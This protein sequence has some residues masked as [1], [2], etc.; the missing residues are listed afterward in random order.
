MAPVS[1][2]LLL[3]A[4]RR[5]V[6]LALKREN[7]TGVKQQV[8]PLLDRIQ[9]LKQLNH[10]QDMMLRTI[11]RLHYEV[12]WIRAL[13]SHKMWLDLAEL[14]IAVERYPGRAPWWLDIENSYYIEKEFRSAP[15]LKNYHIGNY[16]ETCEY[17]EKHGTTEVP[18]VNTKQFIFDRAQWVYKLL[19]K[20]IKRARR[21][22]QI[23][24][25]WNFTPEQTEEFEKLYN[26]IGIYF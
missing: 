26:Q 18:G 7:P 19:G 25:N 22:L 14:E 24:K 4:I 1:K 5:E 9:M 15:K 3:Q 6:P 16:W 10:V 8:N 11:R 23:A 2:A 20:E 12:K 21:L 13:P 17:Y